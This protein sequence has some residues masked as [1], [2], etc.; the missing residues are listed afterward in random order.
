MGTSWAW[1]APAENNAAKSSDAARM[2]GLQPKEK[3]LSRGVLECPLL[4]RRGS[5]G[6]TGSW[7]R[8]AIPGPETAERGNY[9]TFG[10]GV[11]KREHN[12]K[13][14]AHFRNSADDN[15]RFEGHDTLPFGPD[16]L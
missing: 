7:R 2:R 15:D 14:D 11:E 16:L 9:L 12:A 1:A 13:Q 3:S 10:E 5:C 6:S 8:G 4:I